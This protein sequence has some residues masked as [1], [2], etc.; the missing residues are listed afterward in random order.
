MPASAEPP[1]T[2]GNARA[3]SLFLVAALAHLALD[4]LSSRSSWTTPPHLQLSYAPELVREMLTPLSVGIA[5]SGV[6]GAIA[7]IALLAVDPWA[8][9]APGRRIVRLG[10]L[11][12]GF[13]LLSDGLLAL[14]WLSAPWSLVLGGLAAGLPRSLA[15]GWLLARLA[16][17]RQPAHPG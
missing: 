2:V 14:V 10:L 3:A 12:W 13:W 6:N 1:A 4:W 9:S 7:A 8:G 17:P 16:A 11:I 15:V 5:A